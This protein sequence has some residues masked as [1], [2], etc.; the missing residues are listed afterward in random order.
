[1]ALEI[2][3]KFLVNTDLLPP[4]PEGSQIKQ[5]YLSNQNN[6]VVR[7]RTLGKRAFI[8]VKGATQGI[9]RC[10]YEYEIP[11]L[12]AIELLENLCLKP[13]IEKVRYCL[14]VGRHTWELDVFS[15]DN[16]GLVVAEIELASE[17]EAFENP[18]WITEDVSHD[19]RYRNSNLITKPFCSW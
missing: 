16:Q 2:E 11:A 10:E 15:G 19:P 4:L 17:D 3:R 6:A 7:V 12:E 14:Q 18:A 8:T 5:G 13:I 1:M 9:S